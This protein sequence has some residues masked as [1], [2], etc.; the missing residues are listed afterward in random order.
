MLTL[1]RRGGI[2]TLPVG[3]TTAEKPFMVLGRLTRDGLVPAPQRG[4]RS[5][6]TNSPIKAQQA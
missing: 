4:P 3:R 2:S 5:V 6:E 1:E